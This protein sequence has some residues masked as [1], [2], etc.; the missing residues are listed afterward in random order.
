MAISVVHVVKFKVVCL[1][2][3]CHY[4]GTILF[5]VKK[6]MGKTIKDSFTMNVH[7]RFKQVPQLLVN[8]SHFVHHPATCSKNGIW[9]VYYV[10][11]TFLPTYPLLPHRPL[12]RCKGVGSATLAKSA[13]KAASLDICFSTQTLVLGT[14][15]AGD[16]SPSA[17]GN[18]AFL[19]WSSISAGVSCLHTGSIS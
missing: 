12:L 9:P 5:I 15:A 11:S 4:T 17:S 10:H 18:P 19:S 8:R 16:K 13:F 7:Q 2:S 1:N 3:V 6:L 14:N